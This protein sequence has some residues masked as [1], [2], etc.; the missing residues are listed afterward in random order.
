MPTWQ[1]WIISAP[2]SLPRFRFR[3]LLAE[4]SRNSVLAGGVGFCLGLIAG[5]IL[6][7]GYGGRRC[8]M[9]ARNMR[10]VVWE[11]PDEM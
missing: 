2:M 7:S 9:K 6:L 11:V 8:P 1:P 4:L 10:G 3:P 5:R